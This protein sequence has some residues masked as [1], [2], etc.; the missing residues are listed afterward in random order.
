MTI[1]LGVADAG[2]WAAAPPGGRRRVGEALPKRA[3]AFDT[4]GTPSPRT[5]SH[6]TSSPAAPKRQRLH[7]RAADS[8]ERGC[9]RFEQISH[10][11]GT[12]AHQSDAPEAGM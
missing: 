4:D 9:H 11:A 6:S 7:E 12:G 1:T 5:G 8:I 10:P 3:G 2:W